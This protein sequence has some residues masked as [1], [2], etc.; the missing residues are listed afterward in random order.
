MLITLSR[1][2][3]LTCAL[4]RNMDFTGI[5]I[6]ETYLTCI[7]ELLKAF[8]NKVSIST[9][10]MLMTSIRSRIHDPLPR[11][12]EYYHPHYTYA[13]Q[14]YSSKIAITCEAGLWSLVITLHNDKFM[15]EM[16][17]L[18]YKLSRFSHI[19]ACCQH[20]NNI[21][22][23]VTGKLPQIHYD[24]VLQKLVLFSSVGVKEEEVKFVILME[25]EKRDR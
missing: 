16:M 1:K 20:T 7:D 22:T 9:L 12:E 5:I 25:R 4:T 13:D 11:G 15:L 10:S 23:S 3:F 21:F 17:P 24:C 19:S 6:N 2:R 8:T 14:V 18:F